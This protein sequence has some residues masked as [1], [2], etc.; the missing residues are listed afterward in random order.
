MPKPQPA[1]PAPPAKKSEEFERFEDLAKR[2]VSVPKKELD[3]ARARE[4]ARER[5]SSDE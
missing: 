1:K 3:E 5:S 2:L 4:R